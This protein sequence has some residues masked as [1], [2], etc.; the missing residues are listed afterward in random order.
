MLCAL[1]QASKVMIAV[2][3]EFGCE[4]ITAQL[5]KTPTIAGLAAA[6]LH[7]SA[8]GEQEADAVPRASFSSQERAA[9]VSCSANQEQMLVL[10]QMQ[11]GSSAYNM[12]DATRLRGRLIVATLAGA[13]AF[14]ARRHESLRTHFVERD[15]QVLQAVYPA[16]H[17]RA[18]PAVQRRC[19]A[20]G[21][22][23]AA[24]AAVLDELS[25]QPFQLVGAG[26]PLLVVLIAVA[27]DD[28]VLFVGNHHILR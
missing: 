25:E 14:L 15:G 1:P 3:R 22:G 18:A 7:A 4:V 20:P 24:L 13:L 2:R 17:P 23:E 19:L 27:P 21:G 9:G 28:H 11:P 5:F 6:L 10:H 16:D 8:D 26:V 12:A